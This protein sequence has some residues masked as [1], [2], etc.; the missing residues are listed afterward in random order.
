[1]RNAD[2]MGGEKRYGAFGDFG[3]KRGCAL[4]AFIVT[5]PLMGR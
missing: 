3:S 1:M 5:K 4:L 2:A